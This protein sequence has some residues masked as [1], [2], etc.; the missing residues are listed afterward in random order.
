MH[1]LPNQTVVKRFRATAF[2]IILKW[3]LVPGSLALF[4]YALLLSR[5]DLG[6]LSIGLFGFAGFVSISHL[7]MGARARC[8]LC[9]V[10]SFSHIQVSKS[11][12][13]KHFLGSYRL[14]VALGV[15]FKR[16]FHCPYCGKDVAIKTHRRNNRD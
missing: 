2:L 7:M 4:A 5:R 9:L 16:C 15:I 3:L 13:A 12:R 1:C 11:T 6:N 8:P 10:S 14:F